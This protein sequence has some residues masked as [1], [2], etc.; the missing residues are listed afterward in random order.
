MEQ[1]FT[2]GF[3]WLTWNFVT[4]SSLFQYFV[5]TPSM[6]HPIFLKIFGGYILTMAL[7]WLLSLVCDIQIFFVCWGCGT[8]PDISNCM[9]AIILVCFTHYPI[10]CCFHF[11]FI[12]YFNTVLTL[13]P[14]IVNTCYKKPSV[15]VGCG[16]D[17]LLMKSFLSLHLL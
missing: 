11:I 16:S 8:Q 12:L 17:E 3:F 7:V 4:N 13:F 1:I 10:A 5:S 2:F 9:F 15:K 6:L 14:I